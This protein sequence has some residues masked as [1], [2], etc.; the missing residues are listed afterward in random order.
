MKAYEHDREIIGKAM[1]VKL[2]DH[3]AVEILGEELHGDA[4]NLFGPIEILVA[5]CSDWTALLRVW[6]HIPAAV[7]TDATLLATLR[8]NWTADGPD[9]QEWVANQLQDQ[10]R[11][12]IVKRLL[13]RT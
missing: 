5:V 1:A 13:S 2:P 8:C 7:G 12:S 3:V 6:G 11:E 10:V 4:D 9:D